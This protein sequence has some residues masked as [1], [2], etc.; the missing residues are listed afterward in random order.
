MTSARC[1]HTFV[2]L[3]ASMFVVATLAGCNSTNDKQ[4]DA[5]WSNVG[6]YVDGKYVAPPPRRVGLG[7]RG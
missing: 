5:Y 4:F 2:R 6:T 7:H 3:L 1:F